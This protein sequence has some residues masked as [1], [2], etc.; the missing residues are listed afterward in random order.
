MTRDVARRGGGGRI[1]RC[2]VDGVATTPCG[3]SGTLRGEHRIAV[4]LTGG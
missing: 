2:T 3:V 1:A 4:T